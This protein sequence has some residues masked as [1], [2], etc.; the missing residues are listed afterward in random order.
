G[1]RHPVLIVTLFFLAG[2]CGV[3]G[4]FWP[5]LKD[6]APPA[7]SVPV[8]QVSTNPVSW[9]VVLILG[10]TATLLLPRRRAL[11]RE[12]RSQPHQIERSLPSSFAIAAPAVKKPVAEAPKPEE[13]IFVDVDPA[14][15][16]ELFRTRTSIQAKALTVTYIG[17]WISVTSSV[18]NV[19]GDLDR[20]TVTTFYNKT[21]VLDAALG[22]YRKEQFILLKAQPL[23]CEA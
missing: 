9:F 11:Q 16:V 18:S 23:P 2:V 1:W 7:I 8:H 17:K 21:I 22:R 14:N 19:S 5:A 3:F 13:P 20:L 4:V 12:E 10:L 6:V 15:L